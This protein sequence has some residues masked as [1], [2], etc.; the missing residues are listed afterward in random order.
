MG[1]GTVSNSNDLRSGLSDLW[2]QVL[3]EA[4]TSALIHSSLASSLLEKIEK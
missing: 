1:Y 2:D 3:L 4:Q